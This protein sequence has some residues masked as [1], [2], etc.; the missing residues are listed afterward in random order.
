M[1]E[2]LAALVTRA[3]QHAT[4]VSRVRPAFLPAGPAHRIPM[5]NPIPNPILNPIPNPVPN[6]ILNTHDTSVRA[7]STEATPGTGPG[8]CRT[9]P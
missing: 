3:I 9:R 8:A 4:Q 7:C 6:P 1:I 2:K 5:L